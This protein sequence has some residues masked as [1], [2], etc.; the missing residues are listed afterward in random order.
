MRRLLFGLVLVL[1]PGM[2]WT[3]GFIRY[4]GVT[5]AGG[6]L[7]GPLF[8]P[9]GTAAQPALAFSSQPG[10]GLWRKQANVPVFN[11]TE[12]T[13]AFAGGF[14]YGGLMVPSDGALAFSQNGA[15]ADP[16]SEDVF[17]RR[18]AANVLALRNS[19]TA[20]RFNV[21][22]SFTTYGSDYGAFSIVASATGTDLIGTGAGATAATGA[23]RSVQGS[24]SK[25]LTDAAAA[26]SF[27]RIAVPT[28]ANM[29]GKLI[30]TATST[31]GG[32]GSLTST[33]EYNFSGADDDGTVTCGISAQLGV[34]TAYA[35]A[36]TLVC[37]V[38]TATST[39]NCDLQATCTDNKA[40][41]Q[42]V[43]LRW[44]LDMPIPATVTPQ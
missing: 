22:N 32:N 40:A 6:T 5:S 36:N 35:R 23:L 15:T 30:Y 14:S 33:A 39:T 16:T 1:L 24:V 42:T 13:W 20:Q 28:N 12:S 31:D 2:G 18:D 37:T 26:V 41:A 11:A 8:L 43:T 4:V 38:T 27:V 10:M 7:S 21:Y 3:E 17:L 25:T 19:T 9:N 34:A 44:R 29:G